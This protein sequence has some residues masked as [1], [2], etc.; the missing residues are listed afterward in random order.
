MDKSQARRVST[1]PRVCDDREKMEKVATEDGEM[2]RGLQCKRSTKGVEGGLRNGGGI[3]EALL[4]VIPT[5]HSTQWWRRRRVRWSWRKETD[6][7]PKGHSRSGLIFLTQCEGS[8]RGADQF[9]DLLGDL[10]GRAHRY[11]HMHK[12]GEMNRERFGDSLLD[13]PA[14]TG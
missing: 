10:R 13:S 8:H 1:Q 5:S 9:L 11:T 14:Q 12:E 4:G 3:K 2:R 6:G 7:W